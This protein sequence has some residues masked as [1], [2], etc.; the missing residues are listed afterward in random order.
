MFS[1]LNYRP[2]NTS[3]NLTF[4]S[5]HILRAGADKLRTQQIST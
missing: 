5:E 2:E 1:V 4:Q 3:A